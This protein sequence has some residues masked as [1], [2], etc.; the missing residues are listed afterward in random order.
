MSECVWEKMKTNRLFCN[1]Y[2]FQVTVCLQ[3][4]SGQRM[5]DTFTPATT[6]MQVIL[7]SL[8]CQITHL[9]LKGDLELEQ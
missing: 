5:V 6:L 1:D 4:P 8:A 2:I 9:V 3:L 7:L